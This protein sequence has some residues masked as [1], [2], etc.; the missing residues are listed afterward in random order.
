MKKKIVEQNENINKNTN[1]NIDNLSKGINK[2]A[3]VPVKYTNNFHLTT[4]KEFLI[5]KN[6]SCTYIT[7]NKSNLLLYLAMKQNS[8]GSGYI[9]LLNNNN[10]ISMNQ[11]HSQSISKLLIYSK[12]D[13]LI[14]CSFDK[15]IKIWDIKNK[16][17]IEYIFTLKGH[18]SRIYNIAIHDNKLI[19][20][21]ME[22]NVFIWDLEKFILI[23][24]ITISSFY[25]LSFYINQNEIVSIYSK[26]P[27]SICKIDINKN[28]IIDTITLK[29]KE[30]P[31]IFL[32]DSEC[33]YSHFLNKKYNIE[34]YDNKNNKIIKEMYNG[35]NKVNIL[36]KVKD[37]KVI[38]VDSQ[39]FIRIINYHKYFC[40]LLIDSNI[41]ISNIFVSKEGNLFCTSII[42][43]FIYE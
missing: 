13:Y 29:V 5:H 18:K 42:K 32:N 1:K 21:G 34:F 40:E 15:F 16:T 41:T 39:N 27:S 12:N 8:T 6:Y 43:I 30:V 37:F 17:S 24:T 7:Q 19:S 28:E 10:I 26:N 2:I 25:I 14:S 4:K 23:K 3:S 36:K 31:F 22:K 38:A 9:Y 33:A 20:G 11:S 35:V